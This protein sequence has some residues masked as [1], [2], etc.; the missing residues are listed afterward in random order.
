PPARQ[1]NGDRGMRGDQRPP[2]HDGRWHHR[3]IVVWPYLFGYPVI[4]VDP[5]GLPIGGTVMPNQYV[6]T[7]QNSV[8]APNAPP[9][10]AN[11]MPKEDAPPEPKPPI[12]PK[13]QPKPR[14][15]L[16]RH[17]DVQKL[18]R[19]G[20]ESFA[21]GDYTKAARWYQQA[22]DADVLDPMGFFHL[23]QAQFAQGKF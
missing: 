11:P 13:V 7:F 15:E 19:A 4:Y 16:D 9:P 20:N 23:A 10:P 21:Q 12:K 3:P 14:D 6:V 8:T 2:I 1:G 17:A 22:T 5:Y 18:I